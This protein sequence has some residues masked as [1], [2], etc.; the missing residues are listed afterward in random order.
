MDT[1]RK[2]FRTRKYL[3]LQDKE[4]RLLSTPEYVRKRPEIENLMEDGNCSQCVGR[5]GLR[6]IGERQDQ[7][8]IRPTNRRTS[9]IS[10]RRSTC[11]SSLNSSV[12]VTRNEKRR[13]SK[14]ASVRLTVIDAVDTLR[15]V[16]F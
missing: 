2:S 8:Q 3:S 4:N 12:S 7:P 9:M 16:S 11:A 6:V 1:V 5:E 10:T 13:L 15:R 14:S